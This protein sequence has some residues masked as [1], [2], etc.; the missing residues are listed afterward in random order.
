[1]FN[2]AGSLMMH[3]EQE[4]DDEGNFKCK[5]NK[6]E[7]TKQRAQKGILRAMMCKEG[8]GT[9]HV[10]TPVEESEDHVPGGVSLGSL[11]DSDGPSTVAAESKQGSGNPSKTDKSKTPSNAA[12]PKLPSSAHREGSAE[13]LLTGT[14]SL[15]LREPGSAWG[16]TNTGRKLFPNAPSNSTKPMSNEKQMQ[17]APSVNTSKN[18]RE[19]EDYGKWEAERFL[20][21]AT[22]KYICP[23]NNC[24]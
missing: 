13:D 14:A 7:V 5:V 24:K 11:M 20:D 10:Q 21:G 15:S 8:G 4:T 19:D 2:R 18:T 17:R 22:G 16:G 6:G 1:M 23:D 9:L 3:I 12:F